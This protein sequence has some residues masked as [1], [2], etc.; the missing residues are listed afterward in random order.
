MLGEHKKWRT[1][2]MPFDSVTLGSVLVCLSFLPVLHILCHR[3]PHCY[4]QTLTFRATVFAPATQGS[5]AMPLVGV[6]Y[7]ADH[8]GRSLDRQWLR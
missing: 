2:L 3:Q 8:G 6:A 7:V 5:I 1:M 4:R